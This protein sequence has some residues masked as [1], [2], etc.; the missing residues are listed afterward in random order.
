MSKT[1]KN[2][3]IFTRQFAFCVICR[4]PVDETST[5]RD[6]LLYMKEGCGHTFHGYCLFKMFGGCDCEFSVEQMKKILGDRIGKS[7][8]T[9]NAFGGCP[10]GCDKDRI[11]RN[12]FY[13]YL[14][15]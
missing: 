6:L 2:T 1:C 13:T 5:C 7:R 8:I 3:S 4:S 12:A 15:F 9:N 10:F 14:R 11:D